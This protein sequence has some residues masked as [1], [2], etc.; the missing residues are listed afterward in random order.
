MTDATYSVIGYA[1][2]DH[3]WVFDVALRTVPEGL[4]PLR[5][6]NEE[7]EGIILTHKETEDLLSYAIGQHSDPNFDEHIYVLEQTDDLGTL[8]ALGHA[9]NH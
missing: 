8:L 3:K 7:L 4:I 6:M 1:K 9:L 5:P 2:K